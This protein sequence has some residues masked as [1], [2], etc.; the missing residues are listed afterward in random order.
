MPTIDVLNAWGLDATAFGN[1]EFDYG[2]TR[3][4]KQ[5]ARRTSTWLSANIVQTAQRPAAV[6]REAVDGL[7]ASTA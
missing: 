4:L 3:I 2:P 5:Q 7:S 6:V 1:H